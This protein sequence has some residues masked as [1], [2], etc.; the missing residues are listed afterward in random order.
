MI[1]ELGS[2]ILNNFDFGFVIS[3][4]I[5]TYAIIKIIE[6]ITKK[7]LKRIFKII[8]TIIVTI[9][10]DFIFIKYT[11]I[12]KQILLNS[13]ILAPVAWDWVIKPICKLIKIDYKNLDKE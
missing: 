2:F 7:K 5:I 8:A 10:F 13:S 4:N 11:E 12:D 3:V 6:N 9:G 1:Q